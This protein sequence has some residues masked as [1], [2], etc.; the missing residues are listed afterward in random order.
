MSSKSKLIIGIVMLA[1]G[2]FAVPTGL[3][4]NDYMRDQV[5]DGVPEALLGIK[6]EAIPALMEEIPVLAVPDVLAGAKGQAAAG[7]E[8]LLRLK[9]TPSALLGLRSQINNSIPALIDGVTTANLISTSLAWAETTYGAGN[10]SEYLFNDINYVDA[11]VGLIGVTNFFNSSIFPIANLSFY[12]NSS[13][14]TLKYWIF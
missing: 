10:G 7:L 9:S 12:S 1:V 13:R 8:P 11:W 5:Y 6:E 2:A 3:V 14:P 4:T